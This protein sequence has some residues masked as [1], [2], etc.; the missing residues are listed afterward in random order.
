M[1]VGKIDYAKCRECENGA[2]V[3]LYY[4][5]ANPDR[6]GAVCARSCQKARSVGGR[7]EAGVQQEP[8]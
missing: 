4:P 1:V 3:N 8:D 5:A 6:L 2:K 7:L